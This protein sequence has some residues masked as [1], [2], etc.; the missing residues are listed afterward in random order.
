[1]DV[2]FFSTLFVDNNKLSKPLPIN[3]A[4]FDDTSPVVVVDFSHD[5]AAELLGV[6]KVKRGNRL[7][8]THLAAMCV[9]FYPGRDLANIWLSV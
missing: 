4:E 5:Q 7:S 6:S 1:M 2:A 3:P 9:V 8:M